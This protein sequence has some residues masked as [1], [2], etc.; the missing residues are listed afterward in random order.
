MYKKAQLVV[1]RK[2]KDMHVLTT[3]LD[4]LTEESTFFFFLLLFS[5]GF[6]GF[7]FAGARCHDT[8]EKLGIVLIRLNV[9]GV[10]LK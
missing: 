5:F 1:I 3:K 6:V 10:L 9:L 7:H 8:P 2:P 4:K